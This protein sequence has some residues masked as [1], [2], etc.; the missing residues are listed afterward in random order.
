MTITCCT[1]WMGFSLDP[2]GFVL[3]PPG[4]WTVKGVS[5]PPEEQYT[6]DVKLGESGVG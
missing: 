5:S 1:S 3:S 6:M 2:R 4:R